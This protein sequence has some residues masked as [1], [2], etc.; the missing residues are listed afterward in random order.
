MQSDQSRVLPRVRGGCPGGGHDFTRHFM[1]K[2]GHHRSVIASKKGDPPNVDSTETT[3][4]MLNS[5]I[6]CGFVNP[7]L[8]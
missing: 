6:M 4:T 5:I 3:A 8:K 1:N 2:Q 7:T